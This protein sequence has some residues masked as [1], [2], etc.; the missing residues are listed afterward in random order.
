METKKEFFKKVDFTKKLQNGL[1]T[2]VS[3][4]LL[5]IAWYGN[6]VSNKKIKILWLYVKNKKEAAAVFSDQN[7]AVFFADEE[8]L[9]VLLD[10]DDVTK[11]KK[12]N[13][14]FIH[15]NL[16]KAEVMYTDDETAMLSDYYF[17][18]HFKKFKERY[19]ERQQLLK[20]YTDDFIKDE[21]EG[22]CYLFLKGYEKELETLELLFLGAV[23][24]KGSLTERLLI[25]EKICPL[26]K[27]VFVKQGSDTFYLLE[28][29]SLSD[30]G[31]YDDWGKAL[32]KAQKKIKKII[33]QIFE[34]LDKNK[35]IVSLQQQDTVPFK[36]SDHLKQL[37]SSEEVEEIFL[38]HETVS[39]LDNKTVRCFYLLLITKEK[40]SKPLQEIIREI[41]TADDE[42]QFAIIA[43]NR[44]YIQYNVYVQQGFYKKVCKSGNRIHTSGYQPAIHWRNNW[45]SDYH[46]NL[47][48]IKYSTKN[49]ANFVDN[50][51]LVTEDYLEIPSKK[52][53]ECFVCTLQIYI[54]YY[55]DYVPNSKNINTLLQLVRY[56]GITNEE[57]EQLV[58]NIRPLLFNDEV[59]RN[60]VREKNIRL[61]GQML[62]NLQSFFRIIN[63]SQAEIE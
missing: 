25:I 2:L 32:K 35:Q 54:L 59:D 13:S 11:H 33:L 40:V 27:S 17:W 62:Q 47:F 53:R 20:S 31:I 51:I 7:R 29:Q 45:Y 48:E 41:E 23:N 61:Q 34:E 56:A 26:L 15:L 4:K 21:L 60:K 10:E 57:F 3:Q 49:I 37:Q 55:L 1:T 44:F 28:Q 50:T 19:I 6:A 39:Y 14:P 58:Q 30:A 5:C 42:V 24:V 63:L 9:V 46:E 18:E 36:Y 16:S 8:V 52:L 12:L 38:F 22:S 43:H